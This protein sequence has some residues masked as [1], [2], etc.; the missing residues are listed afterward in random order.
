MI[1][2]HLLDNISNDSGVDAA[3]DVGELIPA[4]GGCVSQ[5]IYI[6]S[7]NDKKVLHLLSIG[8]TA[9]NNDNE[10]MTY[11]ESRR[12]PFLQR[13]RSFILKTLTM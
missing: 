7:G 8:L 12:G 1:S 10:P 2:D 3:A 6:D 5:E 9:Y 4:Q 11:I 13:H